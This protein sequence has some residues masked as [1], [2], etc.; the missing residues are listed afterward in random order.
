MSGSGAIE[1]L[2]T[3]IGGF[4][5]V[6]LGGLPAGRATLVTG[7]TGSGKTVFAVEFLA[8]GIS[9]FGEP[10][11]FVTF[12]EKPAAVRSNAASLGEPIDVWE[13]EGAWTFVD[14]SAEV[15]ESV[16][17]GDFDLAALV[18]RIED[19]VRRT[20]AKR[21]ALDSLGAILTRFSD[22]A[23]VRRELFRIASSLEGLGVT[24]V[25]TTERSAEHDG[26]SRLGV[27]EFVL[28]NVIIL[29]NV[30]DSGQRRRTIEIVKFRGAGHRTGEWLFAIDPQDGIVVVPLAFLGEPARASRERVSSGIA[31]L[32]AMCGGGP[33]RDAITFLSGSPGSGKTLVGLRF[34]AAALEA[35]ERCLF[36]TFEETHEQLVRTAAGWDVDVEE[37]EGSGLLRVV[38]EHPEESSLEDHFI[39]M[40]RHVTEFAPRRVV[41]DT[42]SALERITNPQGMLDFLVALG[43][44]LRPREIT[45][46][47]TSSSGP[48][49]G[50]RMPPEVAV[51]INSLV[52]VTIL[53]RDLESGGE[54]RRAVVVPKAR[55][56]SHDQRIRRVDIDD[57]GMHIGEPLDS[58]STT[59]VP[60]QPQQPAEPL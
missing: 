35:R 24:A 57:R 25:L 28:N 13:S 15:E 37:A 34:A 52:D 44:V 53:L 48:R 60:E 49:L 2:P 16:A 43:A 11:V 32:D 7:T 26:V 12:E 31:E 18:A 1:R 10:G 47:L 42:V 6:A 33:Y 36:C 8:R 21:V 45:A 4:D 9:G 27:E 39:R 59:L 5:Q 51:E 40:R 41:I 22:A 17:V 46:L 55:G 50:D 58:A 30:L 23:N 38:A 56:T 29:R 14:A 54:V 20:G 3:G 19:A